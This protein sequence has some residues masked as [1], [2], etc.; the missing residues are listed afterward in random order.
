MRVSRLDEAEE[1]L[2]EAE[3]I[4]SKSRYLRFMLLTDRALLSDYRGD[5]GT[6]IRANEQIAKEQ[7]SLGNIRGETTARLNIAECEY[8]LGH[9]HRAIAVINEIIPAIRARTDK[10]QLFT[11]LANLAGYLITIDDIPGTI[12]AAREVIIHVASE[13][14]YFYIGIGIEHL[15]LAYALR[16]DLARA[17]KQEGFANASLHRGSIE[18]ENT[19]KATYTRLMTLLGNGLAPDELARLLAEGA[20]LPTEAAIALALED[21]P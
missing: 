3:A 11:A 7:R 10:R 13:Q 12:A 17:A 14:D 20:A 19:E 21:A 15:A 8:A 2:S 6:A 4:P 1:A 5:F 18:R 16:G 9:T